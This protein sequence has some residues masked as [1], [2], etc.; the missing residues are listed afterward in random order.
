ME[1]L[2]RERCL[3]DLENWLDDTSRR[4][5]CVALIS[6][7]AGVGK[8]A[9]LHEFSGVPRDVR[10]LW[11]ACD[12]LFTPRPLAPLHDIARQVQGALLAAMGSG[13]ARG[14]IFTLALDELERTPTL[15]VFED[16]HWA[17][18]A[19]LDLIK[20]LGRR[21]HRTR[22][23]IAVS[24]RDEEVGARHPL[25]AVIGDLPRSTTR[26]LYVAPLSES[27]VVQL[28]QSAGRRPDG[29]FGIT[30]GNPLFL[31]E[32]LAAAAD[33]VPATV[34]DAVL[35]RAARLA[36]AARS[37][38]EFVCVVPGKAEHWLLEPVVDLDETCIEGC[39]SI[40]MVLSEDGALGYRHELVRRDLD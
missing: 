40:G 26:R 28:A 29:L 18:E 36:P 22:S 34:R 11:G 27:A 3:A 37:L 35:A 1:L 2:E 31:T 4:G 30:A 17:D 8:T 9:L 16:V 25:R 21:I 32:V 10:V 13:E 7:E 38:A 24:Y 20:F 12:D 39:L 6:G 23:M 19:T 5:G 33:T 15:A 14:D